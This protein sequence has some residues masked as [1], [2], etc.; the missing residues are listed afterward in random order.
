MRL[1]PRNDG[2]TLL[3][4]TVGFWRFLFDRGYRERTWAAFVAAG[5]G[6]RTLMSIAAVVATLAGLT[7]LAI[8]L[9]IAFT[10]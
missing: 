1:S 5:W 8:L 6:E 9:W 3:S 10:I 7:A 2:L 4:W